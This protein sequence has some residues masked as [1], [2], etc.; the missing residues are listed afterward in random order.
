MTYRELVLSS[1]PV[2]HLLALEES[3]ELGEVF[4]ELAALK[5][6]LPRGYHHKDNWLHSLQVLEG[7]MEQEEGGPDALLRVAALLHDVGK[8][9]TRKFLGRGQVTFRHHEHVGARM[10]SKLLQETFPQ[11][12]REEI[13]RLI[14]L[15]MRAYGFGEVV[16]TDAAVR[17]LATD[18]G[19]EEAL[20][21]LLK[22]FR[23]DLT[24]GNGKKKAR[25]LGG[26]D[27][28][29]E[30]FLRVRE[31]DFLKAR[32]PALNG[33]ELMALTGLQEGPA[34]GQ[35]MKFLGQEEVITL[36]R[37]EALKALAGAFPEWAVVFLEEAGRE[38]A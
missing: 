6:S 8:P 33:H 12:E 19:S 34:L 36:E 20:G 29:E 4:P 35:L 5:M 22:L 3:G 27:R 1:D 13:V 24:T 18:A 37:G 14:S 10:A 11:G 15:H 30:A 9:A 26:L 21:R 38:E 17:R 32:R 31:G 7:A 2:G 23:A 16:W 25:I 28:L